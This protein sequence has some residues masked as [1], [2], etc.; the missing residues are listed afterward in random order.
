VGDAVRIITAFLDDDDPQPVYL[1]TA[2]HDGGIVIDLGRSD[3]QCVLVTP[4]GWDIEARSP[5]P[6]RR[7]KTA[8]LPIPDRS[9]N[10]LNLLRKLCNVDEDT[11]RL[12]VGCLVAY[13]VPGIPYVVMVIRGEQGR[14]KSTLTAEA[15]ATARCLTF[16][17]VSLLR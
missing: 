14:A 10:G 11:F 1:R 17:A 2:R 16:I 12:V 6:F 15:A 8:P 5:V 7:G 4:E 13:L 9:A 3:G